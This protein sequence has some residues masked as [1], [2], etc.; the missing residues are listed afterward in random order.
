[1]GAPLDGAPIAHLPAGWT[2]A[3]YFLST[4]PMYPEPRCNLAITAGGR[5]YVLADLGDRSC[6]DGREQYDPQRTLS[7]HDIELRDG[8]LVLALTTVE[9]RDD[10][11]MPDTELI[12]ETIRVCGGATPA[13]TPAQPIG[14][15]AVATRS[16]GEPGADGMWLETSG[17]RVA[18]RLDRTK[19]V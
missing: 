19:L 6:G 3:T 13:C 10:V 1:C 4:E 12:H 2:A 5:T 18:W 9:R 14:E 11:V 16:G 8:R 15:T 7:R 17:W